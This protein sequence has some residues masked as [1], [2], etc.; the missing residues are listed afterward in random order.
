MKECPTIL[1]ARQAILPVSEFRR[2]LV[3]S[4]LSAV[5]PI[6]DEARLSA[7]FAPFVLGG[8]PMVMTIPRPT[9]CVRSGCGST[10]CK[11]MGSTTLVS[12]KRSTVPPDDMLSS[13]KVN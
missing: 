13:L 11:P 9:T 7:I 8:T 3:E 12:T 2:V 4:G 10:F 1:Y 5:R 6:D